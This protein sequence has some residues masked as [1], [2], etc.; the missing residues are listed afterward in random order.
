LADIANKPLTVKIKVAVIKTIYKVKHMKIVDLTHPISANMPVYPG[1]EQPVI[2][3]GCSIEE[4]GFL[5][6]KITFYSHTGTHIDAPAHLLKGHS[7]L[8][9]LPIE[10]F[11]GPALMLDFGKSTPYTTTG[12]TTNAIGIRELEPYQDK[13]KDVDFLLLHTGWSQHW[14]SEKYF[15]SYPVLSVDAAHWLSNFSLKGFGLDTISADTAD[16]QEYPVHKTLLQKDM[17][18]IENLTKLADLPCAQFE[19]SC[20]PLSFEDAD[21]SPVRAVAFIPDL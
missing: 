14:G 20:F 18:I 12:T 5:E 6:K 7:T 8:D 4:I 10:Q 15:S 3:I 2:S 13:I 16:T 1:T 17:I 11:H 19:F 9:M 21:G